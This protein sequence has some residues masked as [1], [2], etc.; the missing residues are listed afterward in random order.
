MAT[1]QKQT[2]T[3]V[4]TPMA[5]AAEIAASTK[6]TDGYIMET[7]LLDPNTV[8]MQHQYRVTPTDPAKKK[9]WDDGIAALAADIAAEGL[10]QPIIVRRDGKTYIVVAGHRRVLACR[11]A[12]LKRIPAMV[13]TSPVE[14]ILARQMKEN[15]KRLNPSLADNANGAKRLHDMMPE[16]KVKNT[17]IKLGIT[18]GEVS[19]LL[20]VVNEAKAGPIS[21]KAVAAGVIQDLELGYSVAKIEQIDKEEAKA[22]IDNIANETRATVLARLRALQKP[23]KPAGNVPP[24]PPP[25]M[26]EA[27]RAQEAEDA[28]YQEAVD[29][30][31]SG[32][33]AEILKLLVGAVPRMPKGLKQRV[34]GLLAAIHVIEVAAAADKEE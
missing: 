30:I 10:L 19:K 7:V 32:D 26:T 11:L 28:A 31:G 29:Y 24:P 34:D 25:P 33:A 16:P 22:V 27:Q 12:G 4:Q 8:I 9:E 3:A 20:L 23:T 13:D 2:Q 1:K 17:A 15:L 21:T 6:G 5:Q 14:D 18:P